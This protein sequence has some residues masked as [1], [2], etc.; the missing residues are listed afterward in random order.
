MQRKLVYLALGIAV[1]A[2]AAMMASAQ[3]P[4]ITLTSIECGTPNVNEVNQLF[5][6]TF[7]LGSLKV[8]FVYSCYLIKHGDE[9]MLWDTGHAMNTP[10]VGPKVSVVDQLAQVNV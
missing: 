3:T 6:D 7:A 2:L 5:S 9:Y 4:E 8:Q 10:N 1:N